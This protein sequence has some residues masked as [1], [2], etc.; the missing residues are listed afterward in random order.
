MLKE[1]KLHCY[2]EQLIRNELQIV[3]E[4]ISIGFELTLAQKE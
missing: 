4:L 1:L 2:I 3:F